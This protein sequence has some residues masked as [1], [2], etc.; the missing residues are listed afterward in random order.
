MTWISHPGLADCGT[1][2]FVPEPF[3]ILF[4]LR[5][6]GRLDPECGRIEPDYRK[7]AAQLGMRL[8]RARQVHG[9]RIHDVDQTT[10]TIGPHG[11]RL[12]PDADGMV[13]RTANTGLVGISADCSILLLADPVTG[14]CGLAH[15][16]WRGAAA[17]IPAALVSEMGGRPED[18]H[19]F[20][21]PTI[22]ACCYEVGPEV[23]DAF[24]GL[25]GVRIPNDGPRDHLD[26]TAANRLLLSQAGVSRHRISSADCCTACHP[27]LFSSYRRDGSGCGLLAGLIGR[28]CS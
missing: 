5:A 26:L 17:G 8:V 28:V 14:R 1:F 7:L 13:T 9:T 27:E 4:T 15:S 19:A 20:I 2:D 24:E 11:I 23:F 10:G 6:R 22:G 12:L 3:S 16:G 25:E 21:G 18:L